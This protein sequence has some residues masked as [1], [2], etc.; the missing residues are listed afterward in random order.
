MTAQFSRQRSTSLILPV[1]LA[2]LILAGCKSRTPAPETQEVYVP[3]YNT[4]EHLVLATLFM[5]NA[6]EY[7]AL[8][9]QTWNTALVSL[10]QQLQSSR[11]TKPPCIV[12]D[13]D[14]T[15]LDNSPYTGYQINFGQPF[16]PVTWK[17]WTDQASADTIPGVGTFLQAAAKLGVEVFYVSNRKDDETPATVK[18][19]QNFKLPNADIDHVFL[20]T[21]ESSKEP[22]RERVSKTNAIV[23]LFGDNLNDLADEFEKKSTKD[24]NAQT[25]EMRDYFGRRFFVLPNP[26]YGAWQSALMDYQRGLTPAA[27]DSIRHNAI[28]SY[29]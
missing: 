23:M 16:S 10:E 27:K 29:K 6:S 9:Y 3:D 7:R 12:L 21:D 13:I 19:L 5:Q 8:C 25:D 17:E 1:I 20:R 24:R 22:R 18:N 26:V 28:R 2:L 4:Q 11:Y 15:V 14:E